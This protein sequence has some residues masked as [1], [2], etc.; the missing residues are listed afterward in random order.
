MRVEKGSIII[1]K[2]EN[3]CWEILG[4]T[5]F[6]VYHFCYVAQGQ[7]STPPLFLHPEWPLIHTWCTAHNI[8]ICELYPQSEGLD[9]KEKIIRI[10]LNKFLYCLL[11]LQRSPPWWRPFHQ[12]GASISLVSPVLDSSCSTYVGSEKQVWKQSCCVISVE[13]KRKTLISQS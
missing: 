4:K 6:I 10:I 13:K 9:W 2:F 11:H 12:P 1:K 3:C 8:V 5:Y 7:L